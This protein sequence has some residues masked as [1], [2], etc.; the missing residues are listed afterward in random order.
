M[1]RMFLSHS[2]ILVVAAIVILLI[3]AQPSAASQEGPAARSATAAAPGEQGSSQRGLL[4]RVR[5]AMGLPDRAGPPMRLLPPTADALFS[6]G[7]TRKAE[8]RPAPL[9]PGSDRGPPQL[10]DTI[11]RAATLT[12]RRRPQVADQLPPQADGKTDA[13][14]TSIVAGSINAALP[15]LRLPLRKPL[16]RA[17]TDPDASD[18][19]STTLRAVIT[20]SE[21]DIDSPPITASPATEIEIEIAE[22]PAIPDAAVAETG[23][24]ENGNAIASNSLVVLAAA[25]P[26]NDASQH[27]AVDRSDSGQSAKEEDDGPLHNAYGPAQ[28]SELLML[29][30]MMSSL[31]DDIA[32]GSSSALAAQRILSERIAAEL[33]KNNGTTLAEPAN[34]RALLAYSLTGAGPI[35]VR[36]SAEKAQFP[37]PYDSLMAGALAYLEGRQ[38][39]A[40]RHFGD[41]DVISLPAAIAGPVRLALAAL[42][43]KDD[44]RQALE[45]LAFAQHAA[46]GTLVEEAALRRAVL[47]SAELNDFPRFEG[48]TNRYLRKFRQSAYAGNFRK[49][50]ASALTRMSFLDSPTA[51]DA[52]D[53]VLAPMSED[54]RRE[55]YLD[56]ARSAV[57]NGRS[58]IAANAAALSRASAP[59]DS[60]DA[61]RAA[62]YAA[63]A[64]VVDPSRNEAALLALG[65]IDVTALP[66]GDRVLRTA[67]LRLGQA[68]ANIP[69]PSRGRLVAPADG[70]AGSLPA[71]AS[72]SGGTV[73]LPPPQRA[74]IPAGALP[75][76]VAEGAA[77]VPTSN[78]LSP[79]AIGLAQTPDDEPLAIEARVRDTL[80]AIDTLLRSS[81]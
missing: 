63:A 35:E 81:E 55:I 21:A 41:V 50:L 48:Y 38:T 16:R 52:L 51:F 67:A 34:A 60:L 53:T 14:P 65:T 80:E 20:P 74:A 28:P 72:N 57:E 45:H 22:N 54:G 23:R 46:P 58:G 12:P 26:S 61:R 62:L 68:V 17:E 59:P 7:S 49:R 75:A 64:D 24:A 37:P 69:D 15:A 47:I 6:T 13:H 18:D 42:H 40:L 79:A 25:A 11:V 30:R 36:A 19:P 33:Q 71:V 10:G 39:D 29:M 76:V 70:E 66:E 31:Q 3:P 2:R 56:L 8:N 27:Q 4:A 9:P 43:V 77:A 78:I 44:P 5:A 73:P 32:L 1:S